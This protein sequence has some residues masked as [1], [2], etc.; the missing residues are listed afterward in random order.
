MIGW[1]FG[2]AL[3]IWPLQGIAQA[4]PVTSGDHA[5]FTR[6]VV[7]YAGSVNWQVGR[8]D[9]GYEL[10]LTGNAVKYD[11]SKAFKVIGKARLAGL[12]A[13]PDTGALH[14]GIACE[15]YAMPFEFRPGTVVID[16]RNGAPPKG[17]SFEL[18][19]DGGTAGNLAARPVIRPKTRPARQTTNGPSPTYDWTS[20]ELAGHGGR[21]DLPASSLG[22]AADIPAGVAPDLE[23]LRQSLIEQLSRGA[24][25]GIVDMAKPR[26]D[27]PANEQSGNP[28]VALHLGEEPNLI[29]RQ[30]G[31]HDAPM[32][33]AGLACIA[34]D[35]L[36]I[37]AW[38]ITP[39]EP[40]EAAPAH[41][42]A[43]APSPA[44]HGAEAGHGAP[45]AA[46]TPAAD[47]PGGVPLA[48]ELPLSEQFAPALAGLTGEFD[49]IDPEAVERAVRFDLHIGFGAEARALMVAFPTE[50]PDAAL[51][52]SMARILDGEPDAHPAFAG[53]ESCDTAAALWAVL[54]DPKVLSLGQIEKAAI[55]RSFSA[56]P[57]HLRDLLG[58]ILVDRFLAMKDFATAEVLGQ[59]VLRGNPEGG[60]QIEMMQAA[61][62]LAN[63]SPGA[64]AARLEPLA[65]QSGP[66]A[67]DALAEL[68]IQRAELGQDVDYNQVMAMEGYAKELQDGPGGARI[69]AALTLAYAASGDFDS[70]FR[71]VAGT[72]GAA[73]VLWQSLGT[74]GS[75]SAILTHATLAAGQSPPLEARKAATLIA[76]RMLQLGLADQAGRWLSVVDGPPAVLAARVAAAQGDPRLA[77]QLLG[78]DQTP[79]AMQAR[80]A[81]TVMLGDEKAAAA[82]YAEL[83]M[84][85]AQWNSVGRMQDW[86]ALA[87]H[88]PKAWKA[89]AATVAN[90]PEKG[91]NPAPDGP[92]AAD[93]RLVEQSSATRDAI[94]ALLDT[95]KSPAVPTQ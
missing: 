32:T 77:L 85:D 83:G 80:L 52:L 54:A 25:A 67:A 36:D 87:D 64:S 41:G 15:C 47:T 31:D 3:A 73:E 50:Q 11:L 8:T 22:L 20:A 92:L 33:A 89:A 43:P 58:P 34:D 29:F 45:P 72:P 30:K 27:V 1:L 38:A 57:S 60:P 71:H 35:R 19:L 59:A 75:D 66:S 7:Q 78:G 63:G 61:I 93:Q 55:L 70:A 44:D 82:L 62:D 69:A 86:Q 65:A 37:A 24:S 42:E 12:W 6:I 17:S 39:P 2:V 68:V 46:D 90:P 95:V 14:L 48:R 91:S 49:R 88:G 4:V 51:W 5:D 56:L 18:P 94:S 40:A 74:T 79:P 9:D 10:R 81:A 84:T 28:S 53:M 13:D 26:G 16:I 76:D 23:P 21:S